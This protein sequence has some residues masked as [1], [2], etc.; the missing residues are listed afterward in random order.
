MIVHTRTRQFGWFIILW[1]C[2]VLTVGVVGFAIKI[3]L[4]A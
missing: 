3:W 1:A 4:G 2:G